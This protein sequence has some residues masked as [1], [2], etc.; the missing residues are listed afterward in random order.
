M[1]D[2]RDL[3]CLHPT[4]FE[5]FQ[6]EIRRARL[7]GAVRIVIVNNDTRHGRT[8]SAVVGVR[9]GCREVTRLWA[10]RMLTLYQSL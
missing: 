8:A 6:D 5:P 2:F 4:Q 3:G 7:Q 1:T 10:V 9:K